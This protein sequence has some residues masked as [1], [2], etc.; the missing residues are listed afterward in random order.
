VEKKFGPMVGGGGGGG[1]GGGG[2]G[3]RGG[4]GG[5]RGGVGR[6][7][8]T[9]EGCLAGK[10]KGCPSEGAILLTIAETNKH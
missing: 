6:Y 7:C 8:F 3:G 10:K 1:W 9:S 4:A 5:M 2:G